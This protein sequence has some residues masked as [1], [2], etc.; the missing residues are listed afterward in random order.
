MLLHLYTSQ[1]GLKY[2]EDFKTL[3]MAPPE[4]PAALAQGNIDGY[5]VAEPFGAKG[6]LLGAGKVLVLS[7]QIWE[8]HPD[9]VLVVREDYLNAHPE[10]MDELAV[11]LIK[12]GIFAEEHREEA[13]E[14]GNRFLGQPRDALLKALTE[15][16]DRVTFYDLYPKKEEFTRLQDYMA[17]PMDLFPVKVNMD[18][19]VDTQ[20]AERAYHVLGSDSRALEYKKRD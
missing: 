8:H 1:A 3:E 19:L 16:K 6:E 15:P 9:C 2:G 4:M 10:A 11:S 20:F 17:D 14:I 13:A 7:S 18:E 12:A 5:I